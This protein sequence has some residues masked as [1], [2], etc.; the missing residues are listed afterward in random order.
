MTTVMKGRSM[1]NFRYVFEDRYAETKGYDSFAADKEELSNFF[2][3]KVK[4]K[5]GDHAVI[6][7]NPKDQT[8]YNVCYDCNIPLWNE[9]YNRVVNIGTNSGVKLNWDEI[10]HV[11]R[12]TFIW[13]PPGGL[14]PPHT[15]EKFRALS[16]FNIP[17]RGKTEI[18]F[19]EHVDN[20]PG[21]AIEKHEYFNP[22]FLN[23][24]RF[25]GVFNNT[26]E[27]R[28]ILKTHLLTVPWNKAIESVESN[29]TVNMWDF[30]VPWQQRKIEMHD[31]V[32]D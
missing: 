10:K 15:A 2:E 19:Y 20:R 16:A 3:T 4:E 13:F 12:F 1:S 6:G 26:D 14:L 29:E 27:E 18:D 30:T 7:T 24:N 17:L 22:S 28:M 8:I 9:I 32:F 5:I 21:D 23:V 31:K 25:H 11:I